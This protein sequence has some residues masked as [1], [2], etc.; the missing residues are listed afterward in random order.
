MTPTHGKLEV[1]DGG[2]GGFRRHGRVLRDFIHSDDGRRYTAQQNK[3]RSDRHRVEKGHVEWEE[4]SRSELWGCEVK[5][6]SLSVAGYYRTSAAELGCE[7][8]RSRG[9]RIK[10]TPANKLLVGAVA[11]T[12]V[13]W[14]PGCDTS[15]DAAKHACQAKGMPHRMRRIGPHIHD[16][17]KTRGHGPAHFHSK[18]DRT[19]SFQ[20]FIVITSKAAANEDS[21][22]SRATHAA[23]CC[24]CRPMPHSLKCRVARRGGDVEN[25]N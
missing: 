21:S 12:S 10:G 17:L 14:V 15:D 18:L 22:A 11:S 16:I 1:C 2:G 25:C 8:L 23:A 24:R 4:S 19:C 7:R 13:G 20:C 5:C 6:A 3:N 9:R